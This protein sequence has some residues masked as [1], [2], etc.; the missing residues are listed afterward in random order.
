MKIKAYVMQQNPACSN[1]AKYYRLRSFSPPN[2]FNPIA[3]VIS[4]PITQIMRIH[5]YTNVHSSRISM[6]T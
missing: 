5:I 3:T 6:A 2:K 1:C 4:Y